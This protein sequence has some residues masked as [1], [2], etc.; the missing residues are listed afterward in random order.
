M[1]KS[2][3]PKNPDINSEIN[4]HA[5][6]LR[7]LADLDYISARTLYRNQCYLEFYWYAQQS[8]EKYLK[9]IF[10]FCRKPNKK[11][12]HDL[13]LL[14][15]SV[16]N[17]TIYDMFL[18]F[19]PIID[20]LVLYFDLLGSVD[21][22]YNEL[23]R[24]SGE[25]GADIQFLDDS[26]IYIRRYCRNLYPQQNDL[27]D[28]KNAKALMRRLSLEN[29]NKEQL[30]LSLYTGLL[31]NIL[32]APGK[33]KDKLKEN[34]VWANSY[35]LNEHQPAD[36][37]I[38]QAI[39]DLTPSIHDNPKLIKALRDLISIPKNIDEKQKGFTSRLIAIKRR[40]DKNLTSAKVSN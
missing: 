16:K 9:A 3:I 6:R 35:L 31:G 5:A 33:T 29:S 37:I 17:I 10:I 28:E 36:T 27:D 38:Q 12:T 23:R 14:H 15:C 1:P 8:I 20:D 30:R 25:L 39:I 40:I 26:V 24:F 13:G 19:P 22:R 2:T 7:D 21:C 4:N 11:K 34:L 18:E 32:R